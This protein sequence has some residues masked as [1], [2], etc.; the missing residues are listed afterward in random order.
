MIEPL[1]SKTRKRDTH[2]A[3][4]GLSATL[5]AIKSCKSDSK[6]VSASGS[7]PRREV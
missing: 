2:W 3:K 4:N 1:L 7:T 6:C 5:K